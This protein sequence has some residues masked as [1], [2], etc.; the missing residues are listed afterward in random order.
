MCR[1]PTRRLIGL[2]W[3]TRASATSPTS[4]PTEPSL[5]EPRG[6]EEKRREMPPSSMLCGSPSRRQ[7]TN[8]LFLLARAKSPRGAAQP[9]NSNS[10]SKRRSGRATAAIFGQPT[11]NS[12]DRFRSGPRSRSLPLPLSPSLA[13]RPLVGARLPDCVASRRLKRRSS[14]SSRSSPIPDASYQ[15]NLLFFQEHTMK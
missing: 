9:P 7:E 15:R 4:T 8:S 3:S 12:F 2:D 10:N 13:C 1:Q 6:R 14:L 11:T 5:I